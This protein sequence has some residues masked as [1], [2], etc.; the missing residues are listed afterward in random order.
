L[1]TRG[2]NTIFYPEDEDYLAES[3]RLIRGLGV[4]IVGG[5]CGTDPK[6]IRKIKQVLS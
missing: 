6:Y 4:E 2:D 1:K 3:I 5:C